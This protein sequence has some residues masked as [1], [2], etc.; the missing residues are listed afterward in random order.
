MNSVVCG[1]LV[2]CT[3]LVGVPALL[4]VAELIRLI[5]VDKK[6]MC[7]VQQ[8]LMHIVRGGVNNT[9]TC[10]I[11]VVMKKHPWLGTL[12]RKVMDTY[13]KDD[14]FSVIQLKFLR[15]NAGG[16]TVSAP[17]DLSADEEAYEYWV[18]EN[19]TPPHHDYMTVRTGVGT[20]IGVRGE[21]APHLGTGGNTP[22][23][24]SEG[25]A[26]S[27]WRYTGRFIPT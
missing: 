26:E 1:L 12:H 18:K 2:G 10:G 15:H 11:S 9:G 13:F 4:L 16:G 23:N 27:V 17:V 8:T 7:Y 24:R 3:P 6:N 22:Q 19:K 14:A 21:T 25:P 5:A 20:L